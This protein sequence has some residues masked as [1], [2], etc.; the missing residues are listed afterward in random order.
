MKI[1]G[2]DP[3]FGRLGYAIIEKNKDNLEELKDGIPNHWHVDF[4]I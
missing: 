2:I 3:G 1:L 4:N